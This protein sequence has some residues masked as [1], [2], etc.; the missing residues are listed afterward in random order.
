MSVDSELWGHGVG[1]PLRSED[2]L[3]EIFSLGY[4]RLR[5]SGSVGGRT[6]SGCERQD[7]RTFRLKRFNR[8]MSRRFGVCHVE[9]IWGP[10]G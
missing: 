10:A 8:L 4:F 5:E 7:V 6:L 1:V 2:P 3:A 9:G